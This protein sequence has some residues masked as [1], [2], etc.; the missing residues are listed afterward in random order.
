MKVAIPTNNKN[1]ISAHFGHAKGF[2]IFEYQNNSLASK[3]YRMNDAAEQSHEGKAHAGKHKK[4]AEL[5]NDCDIITGGGMGRGMYNG[6]TR[7]G[8]TVIITDVKHIDEAAESASKGELKH[9]DELCCN[10]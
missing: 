4:I 3:E 10:H 5:L 9:I 8:K 1:T 7:A 2:M 6:L